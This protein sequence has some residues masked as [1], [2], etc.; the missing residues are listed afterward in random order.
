L[1]YSEELV[2]RI[3]AELAGRDDITEKKMFG[4]HAFLLGG[5]MC[6]SAQRNGNLLV[7]V[8]PESGLD[9][10]AGAEAMVMRGREMQGWLTVDT[11][12]VE[13]DAVLRTWVERG[14]AHASS[15][16]PK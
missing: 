3:R 7:R 1:V 15:L 8:D 12:A 16:P 9:Q 6:V 5:N 13:D 10:E 4:G 14:V 2:Q 11:K